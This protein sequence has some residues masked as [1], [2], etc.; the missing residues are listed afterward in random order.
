MTYEEEEDIIA[1]VLDRSRTL[2]KGLLE[3]TA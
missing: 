1:E 3:D 2:V